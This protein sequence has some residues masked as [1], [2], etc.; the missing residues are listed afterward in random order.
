MAFKSFLYESDKFLITLN[1]DD[2][3]QSD[4]VFIFERDR[5]IKGNDYW[6]FNSAQRDPAEITLLKEMASKIKELS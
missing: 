1:N 3:G 6:G 2:T 4:Y 5:D